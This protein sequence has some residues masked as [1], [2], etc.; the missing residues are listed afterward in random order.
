VGD[1]LLQQMAKRLTNH[2][3]K[4]DTVARLGGDEFVVLLSNLGNTESAASNMANHIA[5]KIHASITK[6]YHLEGHTFSFTPSIGITLFPFADDSA[7][8]VLKHADAAM[9]RAKNKGRNLIC[10][11]QPSMQIEAD[12]RLQ[13]EKELRA[14]IE[15]DELVLYYQPQFSHD[16]ELV[17][18]E[19]L[20]RWQHPVRGII[21]PGGFIA[22]AE[23]T[24]LIHP[25]G[26]WV[27]ETAV[28]QYLKWR[29]SGFFRNSEYIAVN[30]SPKQ[31]QQDDFVGTIA[32]LLI[33]NDIPPRSL[34]LELTESVLMHDV[35]DVVAKMNQ[36]KELGVSFSMDDFGTGFS[37][38]SYLKSLPFDQIK[39]DKT[40]IS[41]VS[42]DLNDAAIVETIIA[43]AEHLKLDVIAEGV[44]TREEFEFLR[45][46]GCN[47]YQGFYF[48]TP[49]QA[50]SL[51]KSLHL[52]FPNE[53]NKE[54]NTG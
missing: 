24:N 36:L 5:K 12:Q 2:V 18:V 28:Q 44:E 33:S 10:F 20:L 14:A 51:E 50:S 15:N 53:K 30:V 25:M 52:L 32:D 17:G 9:Y 19:A 11:Y 16:G 7:D 4:E 40:F 8:D 41:N 47:N 35:H 49:L 3:R 45:R 31:L 1:L 42:N 48:S 21:E 27:L 22:L 34:K 37:S 46:K 13:L 29:A 38:L 6:P 39:I 23:E 54:V 26:V 43:M